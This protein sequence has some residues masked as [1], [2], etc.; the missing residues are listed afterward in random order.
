MDEDARIDAQAC[1]WLAAELSDAMTDDERAAREAWLAADPKH[2]AAYEAAEAAWL[3]LGQ[4]PGAEL[5]GETDRAVNENLLADGAEDDERASPGGRGFAAALVRRPIAA[6]LAAAAVLLTAGLFVFAP[7]SDAPEESNA[8]ATATAELREIVLADGSTLTLGA[9]SWI[10]A[11]FSAEER[12]VVLNSGDAFFDVTSDDPRPF[13][14]VAGDAQ[15]RV[16]GTQFE[17]RRTDDEVRVGVVEGIVEVARA[18]FADQPGAEDTARI[19]AGQ[20][21]TIRRGERLPGAHTPERAAPGAW[22]DGRLIYE[23]APLSQVIAD[24]NRYYPREIRLA[25]AELEGLTVSA[26]FRTDDILVLVDALTSTLPVTSQRRGNGD[27]DLLP[28]S[29]E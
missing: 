22:R 12:R 18:A 5:L 26:S 8:F 21:I 19:P 23:S 11:E 14:V 9:E 29:R 25:A 13:I 4:L 17:V 15:V 28:A 3:A 20:S 1:E 2:R 24:A 10:V 6:G 16:V 7:F 27:I